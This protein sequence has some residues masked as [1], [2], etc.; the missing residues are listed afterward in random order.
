MYV[1]EIIRTKVITL[2]KSDP[3]GKAISTLTEHDI[4]G[5]PVVD[6]SGTLVGILSEVDI[7]RAMKTV[8]R[9]LKMVYPSIPVMGISFV[10]LQRRKDVHRA[11][12]EI[13]DKNVEELMERNIHKISETSLVEDIIP[14]LTRDKRD[15]LPV[16]SESGE[17]VGIVTRGDVLEVL[18]GIKKK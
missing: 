9:E 18:V 1:S 4:S 2:N 8:Y 17:L 5:A 7:L 16:V 15:M 11:L 14:V 12:K 10:E 6:D 13:T 3:V